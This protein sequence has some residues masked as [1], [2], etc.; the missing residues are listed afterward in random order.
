MWVEKV[1]GIAAWKVL[2]MIIVLLVLVGI[3]DSLSSSGQRK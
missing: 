2:V 1:F 3:W